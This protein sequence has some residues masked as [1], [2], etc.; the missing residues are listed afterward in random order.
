MTRD[1]EPIDEDCSAIGEREA[2]FFDRLISQKE[3]TWWGNR[4][5]AG[6]RRLDRRAEIFSDII[7]RHRC[8]RV[9]EL[10]SGTGNITFRLL[11]RALRVHYTAC[12]VSLVAAQRTAERCKGFENVRTLHCNFLDLPAEPGQYD[13][14]IGNGILHHLPISPSLRQAF[15]LLRPGG[16]LQF[17]EPN[18]LNPQIA[19][20]KKVPFLRKRLWN[21]PDETAFSR[22][23]FSRMLD[24]AGFVDIEVQ[25]FE[26]LY[27]FVPSLLLD[28]LDRASKKLEQTK[29]V[30]EFAGSLSVFATKPP[31][32]I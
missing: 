15:D 8:E 28:A 12:D 31:G 23:Q 25:P 27:P 22:W 10:G 30:R 32:Q 17:F 7:R 19:A 9:L 13:L 26:F 16:M 3:E 20:E 14:I 5:P 1:H 2:D 29:Y 11:Q 18:L 4:T 6:E 21:S 24:D